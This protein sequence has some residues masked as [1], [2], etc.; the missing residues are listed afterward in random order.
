MK[1]YNNWNYRPYT[2][3]DK[4][5]ERFL[6]YLCRIAPYETSV[7]IEWFDE[8]DKTT[9][10][11]LHIGRYNTDEDNIYQLTDKSITINGL[12]SNEEY[13]TYIKDENGRVSKIR[14][15]RTGFVPGKIVC[16]LHPE[17]DIFSFAGQY[18]CS[19]SIVRLPCGALLTSNDYY[20]KEY[21]Q[22]YTTIFRSDDNGEN[23]YYVTDLMPSF[24]GKL[25]YHNCALYM[26][27][28]STEY[29]DLLIGKSDD[30]GKTWTAPVTLMRGSCNPHFNGLH[31]APMRIET[32]CGRLWTAVDFGSWPQKSFG[33]SLFSCPVDKNLLN[34][35]NWICT[36]F[37]LHDKTI[38]YGE[39]LMGAIEGN[40]IT[41]PD[42][43]IANILRYTTGKA[44]MLLTDPSKPDEMPT[45]SG[46]IDFPVA[47][48]KFEILR[49]KSG[50]YYVVGN[51]PPMRN[52]LSLYSSTN[53][54][55][56]VFEKDLIDYTDLD[57]QKVAFQYPSAILEDD[58]L[59]VLSRTAFNN[60]AT[61]HNS[62]YITLH[63]YTI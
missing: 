13:K 35:D 6:P 27:A 22:N 25:F 55:D 15:F 18:P 37:L 16:Y 17:D 58:T 3:A 59:I 49:H 9:S 2:P 47:H 1:S 26:L 34:V 4:Y 40:A 28:M 50:K 36:G 46:I 48:T 29:G 54:K 5:E 45:F 38:P 39:N 56:W 44:K 51:T 31:K 11:T 60:A 23:W 21:P 33:N 20:K 41:T 62:N 42:G 7:E 19:P 63:K 14:R 43:M 61:W 53:L 24:W 8:G 30:E 10:H 52:R 12:D 32:S 57:N